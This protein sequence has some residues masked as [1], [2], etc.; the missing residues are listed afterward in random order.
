MICYCRKGIQKWRSDYG[1]FTLR[2]NPLLVNELWQGDHHIFDLFVRVKNT[3]QKNDRTYEKEIAVRP[4]LTAWMDTSTGCIVGWVISVLPNA[5]TIAEAFCRAVVLTVSEEFHGL[6]KGILVDCGKDY[7]SALLQNL[8]EDHSSVSDAPLYLNRRFAGLGLLP[9]LGVQIH[10]ALPCHPQSKSIERLFGTLEREWI[11]KLKG[12]CHPNPDK[13]PANFSKYLKSLLDSKELLTLEEFVQIFRSKILPEYHHFRENDDAA[14]GWSPELAS[15]SPLERYHVLEKPYLVTPDWRTLSALKMHHASGCRIRHH[16]IRFQNTW[17]WDDELRQ[18]IGGTADVFYHSVEKPL[19]PSSI[20]VAVNGKFVCEA[21]PAERLPFTEAESV[22]LQSHLDA[23]QKHQHEMKQAITRINQS[24]TGILPHHATAAAIPEKAQLR[25]HCYAASVNETT[26]ELSEDAATSSDS[27][28]ITTAPS[29][30]SQNTSPA[31]FQEMLSL[32]DPGSFTKLELLRKIYMATAT[33]IC[34]CGI[35]RLFRVLY[36]TRHYDRYC[37]LITRLDEHEMQGMRREDAGNYLNMVAEKERLRF[38]Y[39][40]QQALIHVALCTTMSG[41][42]AFTTIIGR[43]ITMARVIYHALLLLHSY[44]HLP[45]GIM[46]V[47]RLYHFSNIVSNNL[48]QIYT[49]DVFLKSSKV[50][51]FFPRPPPIQRKN[52]RFR[53]SKKPERDEPYP[54]K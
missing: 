3:Q 22:R 24:A 14:E 53:T 5:D 47:R 49:P 40:A 33:P 7:R 16:G 26:P 51:A 17:Y 9:A 39:P 44:Q 34:I 27:P 32:E 10:S 42:H 15:M 2:E 35:P 23:Q 18:H 38:T 41:I 20:T 8:P 45:L 1:H 36:D 52:L 25:N 46:I 37:S 11:C 28:K 13:R 29:A 4:V 54:A 30:V 43:C 21:F 50:G 6:P 19:V 31:D 48:F 12:W